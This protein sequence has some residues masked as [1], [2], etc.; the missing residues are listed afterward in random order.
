MAMAVACFGIDVRCDIPVRKDHVDDAFLFWLGVPRSSGALLRCLDKYKRGER[1]LNPGS[2]SGTK[3][4]GAKLV[5]GTRDLY[6]EGTHKTKCFVRCP[7]IKVCPV[8]NDRKIVGALVESID[9][10]ELTCQ[11]L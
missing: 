9:G 5:F 3:R 8:C 1:D 11:V 7:K 10:L 2:A 4:S 6:E